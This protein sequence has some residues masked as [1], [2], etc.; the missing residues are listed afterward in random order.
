MEVREAGD[1][2]VE[3]KII[4][5]KIKD[6][7]YVYSLHAEIE[8][9]A[10]ELTFHQIEKAL[11]NGEI[12][13]DY[14]EVYRSLDKEKKVWKRRNVIF[15]EVQNTNNEGQIIYIPIRGITCWSQTHLWKSAKTAEW[16][17]MMPVS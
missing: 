16:S 11:L 10:D 13:E 9:K 7:E 14:P 17:I 2:R 8:R 12:L 15:A 5:K 4:K 6:N 3:I 1:E